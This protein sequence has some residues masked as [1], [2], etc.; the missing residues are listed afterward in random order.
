MSRRRRGLSREDQKEK[1]MTIK[2]L[3]AHYG[4]S[5]GS[6]DVTAIVQAMMM[7]PSGNVPINNQSMGQDPAFG[8][9]KQLRVDYC[10]HNGQ[11]QTTEGA[12][13]TT[14]TLAPEFQ[15]PAGLLQ[16][17]MQRDN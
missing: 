11:R 13:G 10:G 7:H 15:A 2:I 6:V 8:Q 1:T 5:S 4:A 12:E 17:V 9:L 3:S 14:I 16:G